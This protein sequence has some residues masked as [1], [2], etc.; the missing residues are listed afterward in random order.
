MAEEHL[1]QIDRVPA[2]VDERAA[3]AERRVLPPCAFHARIPAGKLRAA[4]HRLAQ[5]TVGNHL[6]GGLMLR[7]EAHH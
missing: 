1:E 7:D 3:A 6:P 2:H 4:E 5:S